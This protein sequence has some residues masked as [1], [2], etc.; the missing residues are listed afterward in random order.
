MCCNYEFVCVWTFPQNWSFGQ[1]RPPVFQAARWLM[2]ISSNSQLIPYMEAVT[3][4]IGY[5]KKGILM[6]TS[7]VL[8]FFVTSPHFTSVLKS[9][10]WGVPFF[11]G[12]LIR[13]IWDHFPRLV[14]DLHTWDSRTGGTL[15]MQYLSS[16]SPLRL[17]Y[18]CYR[19]SEMQN[20]ENPCL[21]SVLGVCI[22]AMCSKLRM[23]FSDHES[24]LR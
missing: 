24:L 6:P 13:Q 23:L 3:I 14:L 8:I 19:D 17:K 1:A 2:V 10:I 7:T 5:M 22:F 18:V 15:E 9:K 12:R 20:L 11:C 16:P 4:S 21:E